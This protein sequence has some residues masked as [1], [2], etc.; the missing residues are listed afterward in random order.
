MAK[1]W[2]SWLTSVIFNTTEI[3][4][5]FQPKTFQISAY[6]SLLFILNRQDAWIRNNPTISPTKISSLEAIKIPFQPLMMRQSECNSPRWTFSW[7]PAKVTGLTARAKQYPISSFFLSLYVV[8]EWSGLNQGGAI[9]QKNSCR[10]WC[11][12]THWGVS[13]LT[14]WIHFE[15][16]VVSIQYWHLGFILKL[17]CFQLS[18]RGKLAI[19]NLYSDIET[20]AFS[21]WIR[22][23]N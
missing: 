13:K 6:P 19:L 14:P 17:H 5:L 22:D 1:Y 18:M 3:W 23:F 7:T 11:N 2:F 20:S 21:K 12:L 10:D 9:R 15:T 8:W 4:L 16:R